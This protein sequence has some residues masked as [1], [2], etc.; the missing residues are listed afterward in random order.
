ML[1]KKYK[2]KVQLVALLWQAKTM[3]HP[4]ISPHQSCLTATQFLIE[5]L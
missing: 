2:L 5:D 1:L 4:T 3:K